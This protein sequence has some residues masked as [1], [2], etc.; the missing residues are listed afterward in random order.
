[1]SNVKNEKPLRLNIREFILRKAF[2]E[3]FRT[4]LNVYFDVA[5]YCTL[6]ILYLFF[7]SRQASN[8][9]FNQLTF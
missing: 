4:E 6:H 7:T 8:I 1:M 5:Y 2:C 3:V 9:F